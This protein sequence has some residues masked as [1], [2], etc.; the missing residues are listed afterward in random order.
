MGSLIDEKGKVY[1]RLRVL[2]HAYPTDG[3]CNGTSAHWLCYCDPDLGGCGR[4]TIVTGPGLRSGA[5]RS[6]GCLRRE[7]L[8]A[9][10]TK[11]WRR[12]KGTADE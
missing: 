11:Y 3:E 8:S 2:R 4:M 10:M 9:A 7:R 1:G 6:C 12:K 5:S